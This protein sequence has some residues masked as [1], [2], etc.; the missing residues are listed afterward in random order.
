MVLSPGSAFAA[1][2]DTV[3]TFADH[4]VQLVERQA[5]VGLG[6]LRGANEEGAEQRPLAPPTLS[7]VMPVFLRIKPISLSAI[8]GKTTFTETAV[9]I[10]R[11][12]MV[13]VANFI[14][15]GENQALLW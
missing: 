2:D 15:A 13:G 5:L 3:R 4:Q 1:V 12:W 9:H 6:H 14:E 10:L 11:P 7:S 8:D